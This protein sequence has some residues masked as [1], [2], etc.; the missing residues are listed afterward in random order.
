M[1]RLENGCHGH[2]GINMADPLSQFRPPFDPMPEV[3]GANGMA[4]TS[5]PE[6]TQTALDILATGGSA[7]DAAISAN[8]MLGLCEPTGCGLGGDLFAIV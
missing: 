1:A 5:H 8:A 2:P 6:A 3:R 4:A 7:V